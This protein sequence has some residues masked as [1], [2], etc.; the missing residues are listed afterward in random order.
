MFVLHSQGSSSSSSSRGSS[1]RGRN[2]VTFTKRRSSCLLAASYWFTNNP[3][4]TTIFGVSAEAVVADGTKSTT[5]ETSG[6]CVLSARRCERFPRFENRQFR[7][8]LGEAHL[9]VNDAGSNCIRRAEDFHHWCGNGRENPKASVA[10]TYTPTGLSQVYHPTACPFG[11]SLYHKNCYVHV[12]RAKTWWEAEAW[13]QEHGANLCSIHGKEENEFVFTLT[14]GLSSWIGYHDT[15]Q[16]QEY[17]WTDNTKTDYENKAKNCTG[18]ETEPDCAPKETAQQ[19]YDW[20]GEDR[21]TWVCKKQAKWAVGLM[22]NTTSL[23]QLA[24]MDWEE[25]KR[26]WPEQAVRL[27]I[28]RSEDDEDYEEALEEEQGLKDQM[29]KGSSSG[30]GEGALLKGPGAAVPTRSTLASDACAADS[31]NCIKV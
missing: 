27:E 29:K 25:L 24:T 22:R 11:W 8:T 30:E 9:G 1:S 20:Q 17:T 7:D 6:S 13:C 14:K 21:G 2:S 23:Q 19:W 3:A 31:T 15:D 18:R 16:D 12:W 26:P 5:L 28:Q 4:R 10:A